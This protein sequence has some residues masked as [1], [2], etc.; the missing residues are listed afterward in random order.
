MKKKVIIG[1]LGTTLDKGQ[2]SQRWEK[3][4][5]TID[6]LSFD[7]LVFDRFELLYDQKYKKLCDVIYQDCLQVSPETTINKHLIDI[8]SPWDFENVFSTLFDFA[9]TYPFNI[10]NEDYYFHITTGTHVVQICL[11]LL[12]ESRHLPGT[13]IQVHP[14]WKR[15]KKTGESNYSIIDLDLSKYDPLITRFQKESFEAT[16]FLKSGIQTKNDKFNQLIEKI[17]KVSSYSNHPILLMGPTG[18]GKSLLAKKIFE[19]K[20]NRHK[21]TGNFIQVNCA[22]IKSD[23]A[24]SM[25]FGHKKG[26]FTGAI[27][28]RVGLIKASHKGILFLDEISELGLQEQAMLLHVLEE[29][30][31]YP[32][33]SDKQDFSDFQIIIGTNLDLSN[34]VKK[35]NFRKDLLARINLWSFTLPALIDRK[36]DIEENIYFELEKF[37]K[38]ENKRVTFNKEAIQ[39]YLKFATSNKA[40]WSSNFRDLN[41]SIIR[42]ATFAISSRINKNIVIEEI[43]RLLTQWNTNSETNSLERFLSKEDIDLFDQIQLSSV[44]NIC[45]NFNSISDAG[46]YLFAHSRNKKSTNNDS[47]RLRKYLTKFNLSW[48]DINNNAK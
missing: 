4:R 39:Y 43:D 23:T 10:D 12:T 25:L 3:W 1:F 45:Q 17:E 48:K 22:T 15:N 26:S 19:L 21:I 30:T 33:G 14:N 7:D 24:S 18:S 20:K 41:S 40:T 13:L 32:L 28:D 2:S 44:I 16:N 11:F 31:F 6:L 29:K 8:Q 36:E 9:K 42:M 34:E 35:G 5:P 27:T 46:K 47:D 38:S 37:E